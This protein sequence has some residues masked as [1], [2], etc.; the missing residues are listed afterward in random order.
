MA[1][2]SPFLVAQSLLT[3]QYS[4]SWQYIQQFENVPPSK[5]HDSRN[6]KESVETEEQAEENEEEE[7]DEETGKWRAF[8]D[9][10]MALKR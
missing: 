8:I 3:I 4:P 2:A 7:E 5:G 1:L 6:N 9:A 10:L